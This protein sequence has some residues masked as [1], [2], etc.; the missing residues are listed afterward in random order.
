LFHSTSTNE[1]RRI[2]SFYGVDF[3]DGAVNFTASLPALTNAQMRSMVPATQ[4]MTNL[5]QRCQGVFTVFADRS[6]NLLRVCLDGRLAAEWRAPAGLKPTGDGIQISANANAALALR[7]VVVSQWR[8]LT[9]A[10]ATPLPPIPAAR[11]P[12]EMLVVLHNG[13]RL[14]LSSLRGDV[15]ALTGHNQLLGPVTLSRAFIRLIEW[16][17]PPPQK[18]K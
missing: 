4:L 1:E 2:E 11:G 14:T 3:R 13:D 7:Q 8:D 9:V 16:P 5:S 17:L 12:T 15:N 10:H 18:N 6:T